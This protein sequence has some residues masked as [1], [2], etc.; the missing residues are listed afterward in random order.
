MV[1]PLVL[2]DLMVGLMTLKV[3]VVLLGGPVGC[4]RSVASDYESDASNGPAT[5]RFLTLLKLMLVLKL[6]WF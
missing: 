6:R 5:D 4:A 3:L 2:L 1:V